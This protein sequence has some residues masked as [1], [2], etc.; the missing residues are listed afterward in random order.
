[1][2]RVAPAPSRLTT[3]RELGKLKIV[4]RVRRNWFIVLF[5]GA[6]LCGWA[7]GETF[8][9]GTLLGTLL[10]A[11]EGKEPSAFL[12]LWLVLWTVGGGAAI[13]AFLMNL[14][15][16]EVIS[17]DGRTLSVRLEVFGLGRSR[18]F[19]L[20]FITNPRV[21]TTAADLFGAT[22]TNP[23]RAGAI[24]FDYGAKTRRIGFSLEGQD[25]QTVLAAIKEHL[26][27]AQ[28]GGL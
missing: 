24:A 26:P 4:S 8:A 25:A 13:F 10:G 28:R 23:W 9:I 5:L 27:A 12:A 19:D 1:M 6:W 2:A 22:R 17:L 7:M 18:E 16:R 15:G 3:S 14:A 21:E 20:A 11:R